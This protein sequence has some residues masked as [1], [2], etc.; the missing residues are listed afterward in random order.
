MPAFFLIG[1]A[2]LEL[3]VRDRGMTQSSPY[4]ID[5]RFNK[6]QIAKSIRESSALIQT[7]D[8]IFGDGIN[9]LEDHALAMKAHSFVYID[10]PYVT[11]GHKLYR[12]FFD[13]PEHERLADA[14]DELRTPWLISYD[15]HQLIRDLYIGEQ[16][17]FV[18]TYQSLKG[19]RFVKEIL[20]M[21]PDLIPPARES[22]KSPQS[23]RIR[24]EIS[25]YDH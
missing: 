10:P 9:F 20:L 18:K 4:K 11:N 3:S 7:V 8:I 2:F 22:V 13:E 16:A 19:S 5:C 24:A 14:V 17:K 25:D 6:V 23:E 21:S 1:P 12:Y 15:N